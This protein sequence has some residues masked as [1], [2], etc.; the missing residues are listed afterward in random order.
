MTHRFLHGFS[1]S[2]SI[3]IVRK[4][5]TVEW[6]YMIAQ[7]EANDVWM[8]PNGN[9]LLA[10]KAGAR[11]I[12]MAQP[13]QV[14]WEY[15]SPVGSEVH[16]VQPL[17][18]GQYLVGE[19]HDDGTSTI[20]EMDHAKT[21]LHSFSITN[22]G[23]R[24][25]QFREVRKTPQGTYLTTQQRAGDKGQEFDGTGKLLRTF[26]CGWFSA[27]RL[28]DGNTL[29]GC[30]NDHRVLEVDPNNNIVWQV[31]Q[32]DLPGNP[33]LFV[34]GLQ[35]LANG[36]TVVCNWGPNAAGSQVF[37][38]TSDKK[39]VWQVRSAQYGWVSNVQILD[40]EAAVGG[41]ALR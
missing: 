41:V 35:R 23:T 22:G 32:N 8:L 31:A 15:D 27:I 16:A 18:G 3:Q 20:Y 2:G 39:I 36:N 37:E 7:N 30:G 26:P 34:A 24:H 6:N 28:P 1:D 11:E 9:I 25:N 21:V 14:V 40:P 29:L 12:T 4:D 5:G 17:P 33:L 19:S 10:F 38:I 13:P